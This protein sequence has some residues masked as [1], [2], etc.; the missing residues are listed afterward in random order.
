MAYLGTNP[1]KHGRLDS[2]GRTAVMLAGIPAP[3][4]PSLGTMPGDE[5][6]G[7]ILKE[8]SARL[9]SPRADRQRILEDAAQKLRDSSE[10]V[11]GTS[12]I[13]FMVQV[14]DDLFTTFIPDLMED[15][16]RFSFY[17]NW[18]LRGLLPAE[19]EARKEGSIWK[20]RLSEKWRS[21]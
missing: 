5:A 2:L 9:K 18:R 12:Q 15:S 13:P 10:S 17:Q 11:F 1:R 6:R 8:A 7:Q 14:D 21:V 3:L 20:Y 4:P 16:E 19:V